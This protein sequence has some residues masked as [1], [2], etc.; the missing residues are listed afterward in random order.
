MVEDIVATS[1][2][3]QLAIIVRLTR[4]NKE[5]YRDQRKN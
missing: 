4:V 3:E 5:W 1:R 2:R